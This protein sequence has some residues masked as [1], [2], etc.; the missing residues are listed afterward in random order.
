MATV[1]RN[2][3][4]RENRRHSHVGGVPDEEY[5]LCFSSPTPTRGDGK[6]ELVNGLEDRHAVNVSDV[7][8]AFFGIMVPNEFFSPLQNTML[9]RV[10]SLAVV[11]LLMT[12]WMAELSAQQLSLKQTDTGYE[13]SISGK[14]FAG[15]V[16]DQGGAPVVY[17]IVGPTGK[18]M[19]RD[20]PMEKAYE[21]VKADHPHHR[22]L[23]FAHGD[24][25]KLDY[26][27]AKNKIVHQRFVKAECDGTTALLVTDN[28]LIDGNNQVVCH[29]VRTIRFAVSGDTRIIDFDVTVT[30]EQEKVV[31]GDTKE[32]TFGIR[33]PEV[34][35]VET[36][37]GGSFINAEGKIGERDAWGKRSSWVDYNGTLDGEKVGIAILNHPSS[38]RFPT[39]WHVRNYGLFAANPFG[40]HDFESL[41]DTKAGEH[42]LQKGQSF[43]CRYRVL[44]HQ[45]D[46]TEAKIAE[47][48]KAYAEM[49]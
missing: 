44:F 5:Y 28:D 27:G 2:Q 19:T 37:K 34:L 21:G 47:A 36:K 48:F 14:L 43:T 10:V 45:G 8:F 41:Q 20:Y 32:G 31:F 42:I 24:V 12:G 4:I 23:W 17:P 15:Y 22:S 25:N 11:A 35:A 13:V 9:Y 39:Y 3:Q 38:F 40:V 6:N 46:S 33:V 26:W 7:L 1:A 16:T 18:N 49:P 29:E 30:A